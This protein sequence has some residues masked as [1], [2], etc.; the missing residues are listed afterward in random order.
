MDSPLSGYTDTV[1][2][3]F[4]NPR[5]AGAL[6]EATGVG[7]AGN[8]DDGDHLRLAVVIEEGTLLKVRFQTFG[9]PAAIAA[10]SAATELFE[11]RTVTEAL[12]LSNR[13]VVTALGGLPEHKLGCSVLAAEAL[14]AAVGDHYARRGESPPH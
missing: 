14:R 10:G 11:G 1:L 9:C 5:N 6:P 3:H 7:T 13:D 8:P 12:G 2:D 4:R